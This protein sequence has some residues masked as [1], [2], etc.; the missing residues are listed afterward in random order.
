MIRWTV[1]L[2]SLPLGFERGTLGCWV[3]H[4]A[5]VL[6]DESVY[7]AGGDIAGRSVSALYVGVLVEFKFGADVFGNYGKF[8]DVGEQSIHS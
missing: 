2:F 6:V 7:R 3:H 8:V 4:G 5:C 1:E